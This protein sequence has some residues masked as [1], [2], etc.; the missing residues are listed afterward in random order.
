M[1]GSVGSSCT[2]RRRRVGGGPEVTMPYLSRGPGTCSY[3]TRRNIKLGVGN[4]KMISRAWWI[5]G[6]AGLGGGGGWMVE[7]DDG[8]RRGN[9]EVRG[10]TVQYYTRAGKAVHMQLAR[11]SLTCRRAAEQIQSKWLVETGWE[12]CRWT[13]CPV[14]VTLNPSYSTTPIRANPPDP[15]P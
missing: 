1:C 7:V 6:Q 13:T 10:D 15:R 3:D 5:D 12:P 11:C 4:M 14:A 8:R 2:L 9:C